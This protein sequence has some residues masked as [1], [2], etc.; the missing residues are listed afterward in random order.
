[1][2]DPR[3]LELN[4]YI[5]ILAAVT[6]IP[7][8]LGGYGAVSFPVTLTPPLPMGTYSVVISNVVSGE[9]ICRYQRTAYN[10]VD[11]FRIPSYHHRMI[12]SGQWK[13][14]VVSVSS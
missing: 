12:E 6:I 8:Q 2:T 10:G 13:I 7:A 5:F 11:H 9:E 3:D 4:L 1:M 14:D